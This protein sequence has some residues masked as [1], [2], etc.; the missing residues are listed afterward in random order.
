MKCSEFVGRCV[1]F[2]ILAIVFDVVG[3]II[4]LLGVFAPL[5][6]W[7]LFV[8]SGPIIIFLS[9]AFWIFWYLGNITVQTHHPHLWY[10]WGHC[11]DRNNQHVCFMLGT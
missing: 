1:G 2:F 6:F 10:R 3:L 5:S 11:R 8:I 9:L 7:D 4:F